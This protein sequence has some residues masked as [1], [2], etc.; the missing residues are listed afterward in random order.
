ASLHDVTLE[1]TDPGDP[2]PIVGD[3]QRLQQILSNLIS[4]A[5]KFTPAG[6]RVLVACACAKGEA[7]VTVT[8]SG[9]G[10][11]PDVLPF[12]FDRFRQGDS[13]PTRGHGGLGLG[14]AVARHLARLHRGDV[15]AASPGTG[16]GS[17]FTLRLPL[18]GLATTTAAGRPGRVEVSGA[19]AGLD[20]LVVDDNDD[21]RELLEAG[22]VKAGAHVRTASSADAALRMLGE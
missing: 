10:I 8:D 1:F 18:P 9:I 3:P 13:S 15:G 2:V 20:I 4:N 5:I 19:L 22:L 17:T 12:I 14:L 7:L 16:H 6:G 11:S 21:A